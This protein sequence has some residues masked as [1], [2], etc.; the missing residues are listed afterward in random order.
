MAGLKST[1]KCYG[2]KEVF[3]REELIS[4]ASPNAKTSNNYCP[5]CYAEKLAREKFSQTVCQIFGLKAP[6]PRIWAERER[7]RDT[8][9]YTDDTICDCLKYIY[10]V[11]KTKK[12][13][14]SL[15]L[16]TPTNVEKMMKMKR[17]QE[18]RKNVIDEAMHTKYNVKYIDVREN[19][20][21]QD[22][23]QYNLDELLDLD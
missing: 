6:G 23:E 18:F 12:L 14:E 13:S 20:G 11:N 15:C 10:E 22:N 3:R 19:E 8:Y 1:L 5:K 16:V 2:C 9:G 4:Y 21:Y 17:N 7:L